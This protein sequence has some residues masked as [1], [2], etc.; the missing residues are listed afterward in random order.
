MPSIN[1]TA[2]TGKAACW[3]S[4][5]TGLLVLLG[6]ATKVVADLAAWDV[7]GFEAALVALGVALEEVMED[8]VP[9]EVQEVATVVRLLAVSTTP[10]LQVLPPRYQ[11]PLPIT[12]HPEEK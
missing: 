7:E 12:L 5:R 1:S 6:A 8:A 3:K 11:T 2:M 4:A 10:L 9:T